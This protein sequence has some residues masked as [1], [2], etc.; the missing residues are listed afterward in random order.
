MFLNEIKSLLC[1]SKLLEAQTHVGCMPHEI[2]YTSSAVFK[3]PIVFFMFAG[4]GSPPSIKRH[5]ND[6]NRQVLR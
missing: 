6:F 5:A 3:P 2:C 4:M 1:N